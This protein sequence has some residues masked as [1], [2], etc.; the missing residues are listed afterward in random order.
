MED[1]KQHPSCA[2]IAK[3]IGDILL[4]N[5]DRKGFT[6]AYVAEEVGLRNASSINRWEAGKRIPPLEVL[7]RLTIILEID[8]R[9]YFYGLV[10]PKIEDPEADEPPLS[11]EE[12]KNLVQPFRDP[13]LRR[14]VESSLG[15]LDDQQ[16]VSLVEALLKTTDTTK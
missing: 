5:R 11:L 3:H 7:I 15:D 16:T 10:I 14:V 1:H 8:P 12:L 9:D 13:K 2:R 4:L 6:Q